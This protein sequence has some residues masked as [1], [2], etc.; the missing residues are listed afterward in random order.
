MAL[1]INVRY[2]VRP[3]LDNTNLEQAYYVEAACLS[4]DQKPTDRIATGSICTEV[5][6]GTVFFYDEASGEWV[7]QFSFQ[8]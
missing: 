1:S 2:S 8:G 5:D 6:T 4:T 7:E 3:D